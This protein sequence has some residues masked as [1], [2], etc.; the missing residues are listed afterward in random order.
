MSDALSAGQN[1]LSQVTALPS[2]LAA[3]SWCSNARI[4][5]TAIDDEVLQIETKTQSLAQEAAAKHAEY[6]ALS[7]WTRLKEKDPSKLLKSEA[8]QLSLQR[9][10]LGG[11][12][13]QLLSWLEQIPDSL[14]EVKLAI[15]EFKLAK[16][17]LGLQKKQLAA[18]ARGVRESYS[19]KNAA[20]TASWGNSKSKQF[21]RS[22]AR[23]GK[24]S[25]L[26]TIQSGRDAID[27]QITAIE[28]NILWLERMK[29]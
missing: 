22:M 23:I 8:T 16:K 12:K 14:D 3:Q 7:L 21:S 19:H 18:Q 28:Q 29:H 24:E 5:L 13:Y 26:G 27:A 17:E 2:V 4:V 20:I 1:L 10:Q 11:I 25:K 15:A 6:A 9:Q